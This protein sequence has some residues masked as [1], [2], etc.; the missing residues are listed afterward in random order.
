MDRE[1]QELHRGAWEERR[2][3]LSNDPKPPDP[4]PSS[5]LY[6]DERV[7]RIDTEEPEKCPMCNYRTTT[8][9][10]TED[11]DTAVCGDCFSEWLARFD[12]TITI[13]VEPE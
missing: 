2:Q 12:A 10:R 5:P 6:G 11:E 1:L 13:E 7:I 4:E 3:A 9:F 8:M